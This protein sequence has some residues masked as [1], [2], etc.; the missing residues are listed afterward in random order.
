MLITEERRH[1]Y[2]ILDS[3][4]LPVEAA[5]RLAILGIT[6][7]DELRDHW[8]YG[9]R[10][11][12][13]RYLGESPL[14]LVSAP[15]AAMLATRGAGGGASAVVNLLDVGRARPLVKH[16]RGVLLT[17]TQQQTAATA[18]AMLPAATRRAT[19]SRPGVSLVKKFPA[20]RDQKTR[21][22]CVAFASVAFLE[23]HLSKKAGAK[24]A[25][26]AE[27]FV[28]W[29]CKVSDGSPQM[30]GTYVSTARDVLK[31]RG[32]CLNKTWKYNPLPL[33][34]NESQAPPPTGAE[35][36]AKH[37]TWKLAKVVPGKDPAAIRDVLDERRPV[38][39]SVKT[40]AS[41]DYPTTADTGEIAMPFPGEVADGG[42]AIC[43]VGY[44]LNSD[45]PGGGA[46]IMRNSWGSSWANPHGRF[47]A[48]N[49]TVYFDYVV[50]Y[51][52]EAFA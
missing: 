16:A 51:G 23:F 15:P 13:N 18:P 37:A 50:K 35:E 49:G 10:E 19:A 41:W 3:L 44:E 7:L 24:V 21:G 20:V 31:K 47:G 34:H 25:R 1:L 43:V 29:A 27:Q 39:L 22:T 4:S 48:G 52:L 36:E 2:R 17:A 42:H 30:E 46:F 38:V 26:H 9:N 32:A 45:I 33:P 6:T 14:R 8:T 40:F 12:I 28:Y 5:G 11:L